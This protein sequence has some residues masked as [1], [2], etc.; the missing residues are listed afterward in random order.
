MAKGSS[1]VIYGV[2]AL[3]AV[4]GFIFGYDTN[5]TPQGLLVSTIIFTSFL[6]CLFSGWLGD[7][8]GRKRSI[9][10]G[11]LVFAVGCAMETIGV[12]PGLLF[13]AR[14]VAGLG[15][16]VLS[17]IV[18]LYISELSP[19]KIRGRLV[20]IFQLAVTIGIA[21]A[22]FVDY[23][24]V[25]I[26]GDLAWRVPFILQIAACVALAAGTVVLPFSPRWLVDIGR[27]DEAL[28]TLAR[29]RADGE[30]TPEVV[31]EFKE[32]V[33]EIRL[34]H[35]IAV[36]SY[37]ELFKGTVLRRTLLGLFVQSMQQWTG[38]N[39][40][41]YYAPYIFASA[42]LNSNTTN[43][44]ATGVTG[45]VNV[46]ATIP[47]ILWLDDWGRR[48]VLISGAAI[49]GIAMFVIGGLTAS[50]LQVAVDADGNKVITATAAASWSIVA[51]MFVFIAGFAYSWGAAGTVY[52]S[53]IFPIRV[54]AKAMSL[55]TGS[56]WLF[57]Y[58]VAT[59]TPIFLNASQSGIYFLFGSCCFVMMVVTW[60]FLPETKGKSLEEMEV[61]FGGDPAAERRA[62][63]ELGLGELRDQKINEK[64]MEAE[65]DIHPTL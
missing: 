48:P 57:N 56:N 28:E 20:C 2:S 19:P 44:L 10:S 24:C 47:A 8:I 42:G 4:G 58:V 38:I 5:P 18:P 16:G 41:L 11:S 43:L 14:A 9:L 54:R 59:I 60:A 55:T 35:A 36:R 49:Q 51:F 3:S 1:L 53:E 65:K 50:Q 52:P 15:G 64:E 30:R 40:V 23:G 7:K 63:L 12:H 33:A 21:V 26:S 45:I 29:I 32:I 31:E 62:A 61:V 46:L 39:G 22:Y 34:E 13:T 6:G 25:N 27:E 17:N 37:A